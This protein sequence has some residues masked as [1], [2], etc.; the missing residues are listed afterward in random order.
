MEEEEG[1]TSEEAI[2]HENQLIHHLC[3]SLQIRASKW[4]NR[5]EV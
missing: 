1:K 2:F 3:L 5:K 4:E